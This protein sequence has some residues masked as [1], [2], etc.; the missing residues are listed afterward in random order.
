MKLTLGHNEIVKGITMY[1]ESQG[2]T[3]FDPATTQATF[4]QSRKE[5][6]L[7]VELDNA[8]EA[9]EEKVV[10]PAPVE[11]PKAAAVEPKTEAVTEAPKK[12]EPAPAAEEAATEPAV[13]TVAETTVAGGEAEDDNLF[14]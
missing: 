14:S 2:M 10:K 13:E 9:V 11:K 6:T 1:L 8:P 7:S 4:T 12:E 5:G 3:A